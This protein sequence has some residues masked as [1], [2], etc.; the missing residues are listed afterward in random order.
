MVEANKGKQPKG[1]IRIKLSSLGDT[2]GNGKDL[3][4]KTSLNDKVIQDI[5]VAFYFCNHLERGKC[6]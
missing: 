5:T 6:L 1:R 4:N 2:N 3:R